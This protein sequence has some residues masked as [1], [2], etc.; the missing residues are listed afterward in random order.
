VLDKGLTKI[1]Q[2]NNTIFE[3]RNPQYSSTLHNL[4]GDKNF[5]EVKE[6]I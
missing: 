6:Q 3:E 2:H 4:P 1:R 5:G